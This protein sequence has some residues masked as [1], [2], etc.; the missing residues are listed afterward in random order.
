MTGARGSLMFYPLQQD[1]RV[2]ATG[3]VPYQSQRRRAMRR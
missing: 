3:T 2:M 1:A